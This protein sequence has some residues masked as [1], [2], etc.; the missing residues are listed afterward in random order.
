MTTPIQIPPTKEL[1]TLDD[2]IA[3][4]EQVPEE[5]WC[6]FFFIDEGRSCARGLL[7][8][9][10]VSVPCLADIAITSLAPEIAQVNDGENQFYHQPTPKARVLAYLNDLKKGEK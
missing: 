8:K 4:Y 2:F 1:R 3:F 6:K 5:R 9:I 10:H 7:G